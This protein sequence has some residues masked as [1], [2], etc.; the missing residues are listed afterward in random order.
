MS[1]WDDIVNFFVMFWNSTV[2]DLKLQQDFAIL[3]GIILSIAFFVCIGAIIYG[4]IA[5][6]E[7]KSNES[8]FAIWGRALVAGFMIWVIIAVVNRFNI[9]FLFSIPH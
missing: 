5:I 4:I 2:T 7:R 9:P 8:H 1:G 3:F 6:Y